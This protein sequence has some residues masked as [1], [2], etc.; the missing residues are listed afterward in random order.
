[1]SSAR[2][3]LVV[4]GDYDHSESLVRALT[5]R[6][7]CAIEAHDASTALEQIRRVSLDTVLLHHWPPFLNAVGLHRRIRQLHPDLPIIMI[8]PAAC[9]SAAAAEASPTRILPPSTDHAS[10]VLALDELMDQPAEQSAA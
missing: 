6:G 9:A 4:D 8:A 2:T 10:V 7:D 3:V 5:A 1:M